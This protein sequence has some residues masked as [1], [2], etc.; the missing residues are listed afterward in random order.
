MPVSSL[1]ISGDPGVYWI[2]VHA[3]GTSSDGR[4]ANADGRA[5]TFIPLVPPQVARKRTV[6]VS[7][8]LPLRD[9]ARRDADG[10]LNGPT[11]WVNLTRPDGRLTRL[12]DF[13]ASA[14]NAPVSWLV[15]SAVLDALSDFANGNPPLSLGP[16]SER[17]RAETADGDDPDGDDPSPR[18]VTR[19]SPARVPRRVPSPAPARAPRMRR[20]ASGRGRC[21]RRSSPR[22][23]KDP[24]LA[25]GYA[26]PDVAAL[27]RLRPSLLR[28]SDDLAA[29]R[30]VAWGLN[31]TPAV[32]PR[33]GYFDPDL[34][35][36]VPRDSLMLLTDRGRL[37]NPVLSNLPSGQQLLMSDERAVTGG[38]APTA[39]RDPLALRQRILSEAALEAAKGDEPPGRS[40]VN[41][42][43]R[44]N[45]GPHWRQA[46]F[47]GG[48]Q[49]SWLRI[50]PLPT[51]QRGPDVRRR[52]RLRRSEQRGQEI[53]SA[54][55][56]RHP[57]AGPHERGA[58]T[59]CSPTRTS[60]T[61]RLTGAALQ[62]SAFSAR[63]T[64][65][66]AAD[67]VLELDATT[68]AQMER[69][70]GDRHRLRHALGRLRLAD[71]DPRQR[72]QATDHGRAARP[73]GQPAGA[74]SRHPSR[75]ACS[76]ASAPPSGCR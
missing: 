57:H 58:R 62:A 49:T 69:V 65:K 52:A 3:L 75:S 70:A 24:V 5:R 37:Q 11:R 68:R 41:L 67:L 10:S 18:T 31:G 71:R 66:L 54:N 8:V 23:A 15:D 38:P 4:D 74:R 61:E 35:T 76:R 27:A 59:T 13:G 48:L 72:A 29:R 22:R 2:G 21:W 47:F 45:P 7:V 1:L 55:V 33:N 14:G 40:C 17:T 53:G 60:V 64:P 51:Q 36:E 26:D 50:A 28:R 43:P 44:W 39:A 19:R 12:V 56:A 20:R 34:L 63:P 25:L 6:P 9:R 30:M 73:R 32:A 46:D 16:A 42:P